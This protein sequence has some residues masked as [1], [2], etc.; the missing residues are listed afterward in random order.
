MIIWRSNWSSMKIAPI[1]L[2]A[3]SFQCFMNSAQVL[4]LG[5][6][7][8]L[9]VDWD[10]ILSAEAKGGRPISRAG[11]CLEIF[12]L[13]GESDHLGRALEFELVPHIGAVHGDGFATDMELLRDFL[14][15]LA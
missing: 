11:Q 14:G 4:R 13:D 5:V 9:A 1:V 10:D 3:G 8:A 2:G 12:R 15:R 6:L 7:G